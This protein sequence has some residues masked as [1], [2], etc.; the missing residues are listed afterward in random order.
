MATA[1]QIASPGVYITDDVGLEV[2]DGSASR[3]QLGLLPSGQYGLQLTGANLSGQISGSPPSIVTGTAGAQLT[4]N[5]L[6]VSDGTHL[7]VTVGNIGSSYGLKV[8]SSDGST[9][10]IDGTSDMF[11]IVATGT[12][13]TPTNGAVPVTNTASV[14]LSTGLT[15]S[16]ASLWYQQDSGGSDVTPVLVVTNLGAVAQYNWAFVKVVNTN[17]TLAECVA[18]SVLNSVLAYTFRY[19]VLVETGF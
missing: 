4:N 14:T 9:V 8:L 19:Y 1:Q 15:Y 18:F 13:T 11:K 2:T 6:E 3:V 16:P 12:L 5:G 7:R 17:Q 10:I